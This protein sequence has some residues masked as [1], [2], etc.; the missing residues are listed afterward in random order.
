MD[1]QEKPGMFIQQFFG[2]CIWTCQK[3]HLR[4]CKGELVGKDC[5]GFNFFTPIMNAVIFSRK[6]CDHVSLEQK[7][8]NFALK[9]A[10]SYEFKVDSH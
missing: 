1:C 7:E 8:I 2:E 6:K 5:G 9:L 3:S 10:E 4:A